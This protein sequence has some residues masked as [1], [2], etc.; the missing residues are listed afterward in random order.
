MILINQITKSKKTKRRR[1]KTRKTRT[2]ALKSSR[3]IRMKKMTIFNGG[4]KWSPLRTKNP[5]NSSS[6]ST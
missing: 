3:M 1:R 4:L 5:V 6:E 2:T